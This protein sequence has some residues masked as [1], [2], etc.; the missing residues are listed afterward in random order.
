M[1]LAEY[2]LF[3]FAF[4]YNDSTWVVLLIL[5]LTVLDCGQRCVLG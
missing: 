2:I 1:C 4:L 5:V 3:D